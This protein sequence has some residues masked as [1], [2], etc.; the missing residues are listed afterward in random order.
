MHANRHLGQS[1]LPEGRP[2]EKV[3][4]R[5]PQLAASFI[6][7][8]LY[9]ESPLSSPQDGLSSR[10]THHLKRRKKMGFAAINPSCGLACFDPQWPGWKSAV[11]SYGEFGG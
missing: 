5:P 10:E 6:L 9:V 7:A 2:T 3:T 1:Q 8:C 4:S 11:A